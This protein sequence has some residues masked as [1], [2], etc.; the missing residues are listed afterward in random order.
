MK[1]F[2]KETTEKLQAAIPMRIATKFKLLIDIESRYGYFK[3]NGPE[4]TTIFLF[5]Y[6]KLGDRFVLQYSIPDLKFQYIF[7]NEEID[8]WGILDRKLDE[9]FKVDSEYEWG[10]QGTHNPNKYLMIKIRDFDKE[11]NVSEVYEPYVLADG[12]A[13]IDIDPIKPYIEE[14]HSTYKYFYEEKSPTNIYIAWEDCK[15]CEKKL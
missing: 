9:N 7:T 3:F 4:L 12:L 10:I 11:G 5:I 15:G 2:N 6:T 8:S 13:S 1:Q 14:M